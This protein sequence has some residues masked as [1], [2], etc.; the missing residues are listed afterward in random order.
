MPP[1]P[2][3]WLSNINRINGT[4]G[5]EPIAKAGRGIPPLLGPNGRDTANIY[6]GM[7]FDGFRG[8]INFS[9][10][11]P[12]VRFNFFP[13]P[14][15]SY[16]NVIEFNPR[17]QTSIKILV[18]ELNWRETVRFLQHRHALDSFPYPQTT[19]RDKSALYGQPTSNLHL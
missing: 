12:Q 15:C 1:V 14:T 19:P 7:V 8:Y 9:S 4:N 10:S 17:Q 2:L 11:L 13:L 18:S 3:D 5:T 6:V 16:L